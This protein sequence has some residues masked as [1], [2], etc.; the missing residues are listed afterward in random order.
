MKTQFY[1]KKC[2]TNSNRRHQTTDVRNA[3]DNAAGCNMFLNDQPAFI[4]GAVMLQHNI[5]TKQQ[6]KKVFIL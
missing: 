2:V 6:L 5:R 1:I 4:L 3:L